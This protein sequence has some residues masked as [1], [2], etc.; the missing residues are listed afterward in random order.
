MKEEKSGIDAILSKYLV[1]GGQAGEL[2]LLDRLKSRI[3]NDQ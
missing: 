3:A 2:T 1:E